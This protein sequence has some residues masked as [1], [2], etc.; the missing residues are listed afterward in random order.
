[1]VREWDESD[2]HNGLM[3]VPITIIT[4]YLGAGKTTLLRRIADES[5]RKIAILM[6]EF[7]Q[8]AIDSRIVEGKN[9][10]MAELAGGCVCCSLSGEFEA[11]PSVATIFVRRRLSSSGCR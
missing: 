4:G 11:G 7:G 9:I 6:N 5:G 3:K 8:I 2:T 10:K 1:M